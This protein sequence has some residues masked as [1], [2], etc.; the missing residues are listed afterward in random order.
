MTEEIKEL[1]LLERK[2]LMIKQEE[3]KKV[4]VKVKKLEKR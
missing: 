4:N 3:Q 1:L 2:L